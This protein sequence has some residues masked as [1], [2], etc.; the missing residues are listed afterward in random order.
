MNNKPVEDLK[1]RWL[2][3]RDG[4][5][6]ETV[7]KLTEKLANYYYSSWRPWYNGKTERHVSFHDPLTT[8]GYQ[9]DNGHIASRPLRVFYIAEDLDM[10]DVLLLHTIA[11]EWEKEKWLAV[12]DRF[13]GKTGR[14]ITPE[15]A[16]SVIVL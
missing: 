12:S 5:S 13:N 10:E 14:S 16:K 6:A 7:A 1:E 4:R 9:T 11:A 15:Q 8:D 3:L 2:S